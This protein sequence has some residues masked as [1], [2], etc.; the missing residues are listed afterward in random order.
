MK[1]KYSYLFFAGIMALSFYSCSGVPKNNESVGESAEDSV[2]SELSEITEKS[3]ILLDDEQFIHWYGRTETLE[4][5][6]VGFD[7]TAS[8]FEVKFR[9]TVLEMNFTSTKY[10]S[11]TLRVY[12]T[13][14]TDGEDYRTAPFYALDE[15]EKTLS[16][17]VEEGEHTVK[18]L[19]RSEASQSRVRLDSVITDGVFLKIDG[20]NDRFM[21]IYGDSITCGYGNVDSVQTDGFSTR[22]EDGLATYGFIASEMLGAECSIL[23]CSG[24]AICQNVWNSELKIPDLLNRSSYYDATEY[25]NKRIPQLVVIN[26]G[27][28]DNTY[29]NQASGAEKQ[30]RKQAFIQAYANFLKALRTKYPGVKIIC[31]TNMLNEGETMEYLIG[32]AINEAGYDTDLVLLSLPSYAGDGIGADGH[33]TYI[34]HEKA[35]DVLANK[36]KE[37]MN[38]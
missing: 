23:S 35:A 7:Y 21:E 37:E 36:I 12:L 6:A 27:A 26:G 28:N 1:K 24:M 13:V 33:P 9:G 2:G 32:L 31:C 34:T 29:I 30:S 15:S 8:G 3:E 14:I 4:S 20:R 38:W 16:V 22:T 18:V 10:D 5:G 19:K 25:K 11:D 17:K